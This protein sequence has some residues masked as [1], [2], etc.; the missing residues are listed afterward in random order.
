M[1]AW[2]ILNMNLGSAR[3]PDVPRLPE[4]AFQ[5]QPPTEKSILDFLD[6]RGDARIFIV[7]KSLNM[8][9][10][11]CASAMARL[12]KKDHV[13]K[14]VEDGFTYYSISKSCPQYGNRDKR[15]REQ[16]AVAQ[17]QC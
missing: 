5:F 6:K 9:R 10:E 3:I 4:D 17:P 8:K 14:Y 16:E 7:H 12:L 13:Y 2:D 15:Q 1:T 11:T